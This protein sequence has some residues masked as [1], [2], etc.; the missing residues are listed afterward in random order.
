MGIED[1]PVSW[2][3]RRITRDLAPP[4]RQQVL[5]PTQLLAESEYP[6][7][8]RPDAVIVGA[9]NGEQL[10]GTGT[11]FPETAPDEVVAKLGEGTSWR[12]RGMAVLAEYRNQRVG[13]QLLHELLAAAAAGGDT[14]VWCNAR[15]PAQSFYTRNGFDTYTDE[16]EVPPIG[17]HVVMARRVGSGAAPN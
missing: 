5:R 16:F 2:S 14:V 6:S 1:A 8:S 11:V 7:D 12:I 9:F 17:M 13:E 4:L 15:V 10:I 3:I